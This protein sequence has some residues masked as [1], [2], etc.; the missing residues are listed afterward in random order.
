MSEYIVHI[1]IQICIT[2]ALAVSVN[3]LAGYCGLVSFGQLVFFGIGAYSAA[4]LASHGYTVVW[5]VALL[6]ASGGAML[7][8]WGTAGLKRDD[9]ALATFAL[10]AI[11]WMILQNWVGLTRGPM[12]VAGIPSIELFGLAFAG[13]LTFWIIALSLLVTCFVVAHRLVTRP[14]G[15]AM[16]MMRDD[17]ELAES[18]GRNTWRL[19]RDTMV[20]ASVMAAA[21]GVCQASY[22]GF[23]Y[24]GSF[25]PM[26]S[27]LLLATVIVGGLGRF[28][29]PLIGAC[30]VVCFPEVLRLIGLGSAHTA[31]IRQILMS[32]ILILA[33][34]QNRILH[35]RSLFGQQER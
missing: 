21:A 29:S 24:P 28:W 35:R 32:T 30:I 22:V 8:A 23:V 5:A 13:P 17:E 16:R 19:R 14:F 25:S 12:G 2:S 15:M 10:N 34:L 18:F 3:L 6:L 1:L 20:V 7:Q 9:F 31:N 26:E 4:L 11:F 27:T 33:I